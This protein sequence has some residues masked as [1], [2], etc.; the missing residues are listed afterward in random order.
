M[1]DKKISPAPDKV[2]VVKGLDE[3]MSVLCVHAVPVCLLALNAR[4]SLLSDADPPP[5]SSGPTSSPL[6]LSEE[7]TRMHFATLQFLHNPELEH[8]FGRDFF[9][10]YAE[11]VRNSLLFS[12]VLW[13]LFVIL[14]ISKVSE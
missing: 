1:S 9:K 2:L 5:S 3:S 12:W 6:D 10:K 14:D 8:E 7:R 11:A 4:W 13:A